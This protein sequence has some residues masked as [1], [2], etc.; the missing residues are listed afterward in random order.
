MMSMCCE[1]RPISSWVSRSA[2]AIASAS[3]ASTRPPGKLIWPGWCFM[4]IGRC[5]SSSVSA[6]R[7]TSGTSTAA[8]LYACPAG[9]SRPANWPSPSISWRQARC[10]AKR[11][12][13]CCGVMPRT[14]ARPALYEAGSCGAIARASAV[15]RVALRSVAMGRMVHAGQTIKTSQASQAMRR[16]RQCRPAGQPKNKTGRP[17]PAR[18]ACCCQ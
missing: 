6:S 9:N 16:C 8:G 15:E 12:R 18:P 5:V 4:C 2:V 17:S 11:M 14:A 10:S 1:A 7:C 13:N 3:D